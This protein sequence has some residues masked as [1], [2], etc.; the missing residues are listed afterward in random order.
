MMENTD[1]SIRTDQRAMLVSKLKRG[2][3]FENSPRVREALHIWQEVVQEAGSSKQNIPLSVIKF[4]DRFQE[5][6]QTNGAKRCERF[7]KLEENPEV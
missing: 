4:C 5:Y 2:Q 1:M 3:L 7:D 6:E